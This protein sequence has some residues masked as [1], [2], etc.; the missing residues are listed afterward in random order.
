[1]LDRLIAP[2]ITVAFLAA[3]ALWVPMLCLIERTIKFIAST[4]S[5]R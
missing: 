2:I 1:M 3:L 4:L 5:R